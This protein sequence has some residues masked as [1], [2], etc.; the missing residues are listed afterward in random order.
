MGFFMSFKSERSFP[1]LTVDG[2]VFIEDDEVVLVRRKYPPFKGFWAL[3]GGF[4]EYGETV[5]EAVKREIF[6]ET[7]LKVEII[8]LVG[9]YSNPSRD[10]RGHVVTIVFKC[11]AL[12]RHLEAKTDAELVKNFKIPGL[13]NLNLA[14]DH[15]KILKDAKIIR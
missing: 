10:P 6:E 9:V 13:K 3:P 11:K 8:S 12:T 5:E 1:R 7:S 14:F 4:V 15:G 2:I